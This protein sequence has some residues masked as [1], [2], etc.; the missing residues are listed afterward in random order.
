M[1][2]LNKKEI[3][4]GL[5]VEDMKIGDG[6]EA[7]E[8][9]VVL[10]HYHGTLRADPKVEF[11]STFKNGEPLGF[12]LAH[13]IPGWQ[14]GIPGMKVGGVRRLTIP[15]AMAYGDKAAGPLVP[16]NS[17]LVFVVQLVDV[18]RIEDIKVGEGEAAGTRW[19]ALTAY[20]ITDA[21]GKV[22]EKRDSSDPYIW[23]SGEYQALTLGFEGMKRG[24]KRK[25]V[26]PAALNH[27]NPGFGA[28]RPQNVP[29]TIEVELL[30]L[31]I[32]PPDADA[33]GC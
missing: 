24:G 31:K 9:A 11:D 15:A 27:S 32:V 2:A 23:T 30:N 16:A 10:A 21:G 6:V 33:P 3:E 26:V 12:P 29:V 25:I 14:R 18:M 17:D 13:V 20:T 19:A 5:V 1:A 28:T 22:I 8:G 4:G 7:K